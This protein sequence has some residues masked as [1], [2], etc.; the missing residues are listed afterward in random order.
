MSP[1][2]QEWSQVRRSIQSQ[3]FEHGDAA[4]FLQA[5]V[6][7]VRQPLDISPPD[8]LNL[9]EQMDARQ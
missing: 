4:I 3:H 7:E 9:E 8:I 5:L 2:A 6:T 1:K